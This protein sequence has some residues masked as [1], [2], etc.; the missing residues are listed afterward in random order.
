MTAKILTSGLA[1]VLL[2][3]ACTSATPP[4]PTPGPTLTPSATQAPSA[5]EPGQTSLPTAIPASP[6]PTVSPTDSPTAT[7]TPTLAPQAV[8]MPFVPVVS[9]WST[10]SSISLD[11]LRDA[12][13]RGD[14]LIADPDIPAVTD[15]LGIPPYAREQS[16]IAADVR[17]SVRDEGTLGILRATEVDPS[18]RALAIGGVNLFGNDRIQSL[19]EWPLTA[20]VQSTETWRQDAAWTLVAAGDIMLDRG[21]ARQTTILGK[22]ADYLFNGGTARVTRVRCCSFYNY[23]YPDVERTGNAGAVRKL[24]RGADITMANLETAVLENAPYHDSGFRFTSDASLLPAFADAGFDLLSLANNHSRDAG[25]RGLTTA[26]EHLDAL[27]IAHSGAG[28]DDVD[29][30]RP[31]YLDVG[32]GRV[33]V[34]ACDA[35]RPSSRAKPGKVGTLNCRQ[36]PMRE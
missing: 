35:I 28:M 11:G 19:D 4:T 31:T 18:V 6:D 22:G 30:A 1:L 26:M 16:V 25:A 29:A 8:E 17:R 7:P 10:R 15:A 32:Q 21:V 13:S 2:G 14:V 23:E 3:A 27:G 24:L 9:F 33:A 5:T 34:I 12:V 36:G 20:T